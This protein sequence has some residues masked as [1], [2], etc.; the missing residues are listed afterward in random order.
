MPVRWHK[1]WLLAGW[2][3]A[4]GLNPHPDIPASGVEPGPP[5]MGIGGKGG[6]DS[7]STAGTP[8][9]TP[10][11][12]GGLDIGSYSG[13]SGELNGEGGGPDLGPS[14]GGAAGADQ[15]APGPAK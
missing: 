15:L 9:N 11:S 10:G 1:W 13:D 2:V 7:P 3:S 12:A 8:N 6:I 5:P 14:E 4:C